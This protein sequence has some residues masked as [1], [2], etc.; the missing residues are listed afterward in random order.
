MM[1][2]LRL[3]LFKHVISWWDPGHWPLG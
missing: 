2:V 1:T 3:E